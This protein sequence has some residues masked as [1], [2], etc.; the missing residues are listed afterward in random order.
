MPADGSA[1]LIIH[2]TIVSVDPVVPGGRTRS[3]RAR[4]G[5]RTIDLPPCIGSMM[6]CE[7]KVEQGKLHEHASPTNRP[8]L[9]IG[10]L[11]DVR[12][13]RTIAV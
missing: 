7:P 10:H 9:G 12:C 5:T 11:I 2:C 1:R 8:G 4:A 13:G 6:L 3:A